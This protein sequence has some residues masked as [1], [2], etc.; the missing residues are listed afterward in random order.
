MSESCCSQQDEGY[1]ACDDV[2]CIIAHLS[3][4]KCFRRRL[5]PILPADF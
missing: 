3:Y 2:R 5:P 1:G 4:V